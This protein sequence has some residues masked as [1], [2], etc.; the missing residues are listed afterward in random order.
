MLEEKGREK[1]RGI[2]PKI[3]V[4][5]LETLMLWGSL[6]AS[7][8]GSLVKVEAIRNKEKLEQILK[9]NYQQ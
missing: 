3:T 5:H 9:E 7:T 8:T 1:G 6:I 2:I 4:S